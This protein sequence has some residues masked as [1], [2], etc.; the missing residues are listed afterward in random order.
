MSRVSDFLGG[1][2]DNN[3]EPGGRRWCPRTKLERALR[4]MPE[5]ETDIDPVATVLHDLVA[6]GGLSMAAVA[7]LITARFTMNVAPRTVREW[8]AQTPGLK[9]R[10]EATQKRLDNR[11]LREKE[12]ARALGVC[13]RRDWQYWVQSEARRIRKRRKRAD[14][15]RYAMYLHNK[16]TGQT[17]DRSYRNESGSE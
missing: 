8:V 11:F 4:I 13:G 7:R 10:I 3:R 16:R 6:V 17:L 9:A 2:P 5:Y 14:D 15:K 1:A 12:Q